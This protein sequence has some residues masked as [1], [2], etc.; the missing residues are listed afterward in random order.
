MV[1][2]SGIKSKRKLPLTAQAAGSVGLA[3]AAAGSLAS[4]CMGA[5]NKDIRITPGINP[6]NRSF[7]YKFPWAENET[8]FLNSGPHPDVGLV[9][10]KDSLDFAPPEVVSCKNNPHAVVE[11]RF[12]R[13]AHGGTVDIVGDEGNEKDA[14]HSIVEIQQDD[15]YE[16]RYVHLAKIKVKLG[17]KVAQGD[18]LGSPSCE[19]PPSGANSGAHVHFSL[20]ENHVPI[21]ITRLTISGW[22]IQTAPGDYNGTMTTGG[23]LRTADQ[24]R[25][26]TNTVCGGIRNDLTSTSNLALAPTIALEPTI[27]GVATFGPLEINTPELQKTRTPEEL[28][29]DR[30]QEAMDRT[31]RFIDL[32][33]SGTPQDLQAAYE[34][35]MTRQQRDAYYAYYKFATL[36]FIADC[37]DEMH[38]G[39][40]QLE[41]LS[42]YRTNVQPVTTETQ[43]INK[44]RG[45]LPPDR[46]AIGVTFRFR[47]YDTYH[48]GR[49][50]FQ[51]YEPT[52]DETFLEFQDVGGQLLIAETQLCLSSRTPLGKVVGQP[53]GQ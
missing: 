47:D 14:L 25:C 49:Q 22:E 28:L 53:S 29:S 4:T 36:E 45:L 27:K 2:R 37:S 51:D 44:E 17:Q 15:G 16:T 20:M 10:V 9:G 12:V 39:E 38:K 46:F 26:A 32:L 7:E 31:Q 19:H 33:F 35:Q 41:G 34:M 30:W 43:R 8:W 23:I 5:D 21:E 48:G 6:Q 13:A 11:N 3:F 1:E 42:R 52:V 50:G 24:R 40:F 18:V